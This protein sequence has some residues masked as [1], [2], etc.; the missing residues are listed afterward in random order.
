MFKLSVDREKIVY[1][2]SLNQS[3]ECMPLSVVTLSHVYTVQSMYENILLLFM[4]VFS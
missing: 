3:V 1:R 2:L 4:P